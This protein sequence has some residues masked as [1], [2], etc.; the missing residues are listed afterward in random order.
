MTNSPVSKEGFP[1]R[2][3][4]L[5]KERGLSQAEF[6][7]LVGV[8]YLQIGRY[9]RGQSFPAAV[10]LRRIAE[11]LNT[12]TDYLIDGATDALAVD[13]LSD[14][15]LLK[16]FQLIEKLPEDQKGFVIR[17]IDSLLVKQQVEQ[18]MA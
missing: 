9:E 8:N 6:G 5:R 3:K 15:K 11:A 2:L 1:D 16:Q 14:Q 10:T 17:V 7:D 13:R 4:R 12:T 18:V